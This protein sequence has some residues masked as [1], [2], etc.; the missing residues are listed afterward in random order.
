MILT[1]RETDGITG[2]RLTLGL[3]AIDNGELLIRDGKNIKGIPPISIGGTINHDDLLHLAWSVAGHTIDADIEFPDNI[4]SV[5]GTGG[6]SEIYFDGNDLI[7]DSQVVGAGDFVFQNGSMIIEQNIGIVGDTNLIQLTGANKMLLNGTLEA[8]LIGIGLNTN[9]TAMLWIRD[10]TIDTINYIYGCRIDMTKTAGATNTADTLEGVRVNLIL[11]QVGGTIGKMRGMKQDVTLDEGEI[12]DAG[13]ASSIYVIE[14]YLNLEGG[15]IWGNA[16]GTRI[17]CIQRAVTEV[18][19]DFTVLSLEGEVRDVSD[20]GGTV[21]MLR[22]DDAR[23]L[24]EAFDYNIYQIGTTTNRFGGDLQIASDTNGLVLGSTQQATIKYNGTYNTFDCAGGFNFLNGSV[25]IGYAG[26]PG[27]LLHI[28]EDTFAQ[29]IIERPHNGIYGPGILI[30][31]SRGADTA[32]QDNDLCGGLYFQFLND[33][34]PKTW[35]TAAFIQA[36]VLD[37]SDTT[38]DAQ[39]EFHTMRA[40]TITLGAYLDQNGGFHVDADVGTADDPVALF[41]DYDD[42]KELQRIVQKFDMQR[43]CEIGICEKV[44]G[45][46]YKNQQRFD[47]LLAGGVYQ[48]AERYVKLENRI[49]ELEN[50]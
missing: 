24:S 49:E 47:A 44:D 31:K 11:N 38:E 40:G 42:P 33:G 16:Y 37:A 17:L 1:F 45:R 8:S 2:D 23:V 22:M 18:V 36:K 35:E 13:T 27:A 50:A 30:K 21:S 25:R 19:G 34:T 28:H 4:A 5:Y 7:F 12:G 43:A 3:T 15:K 29:L 26:A 14:S 20:V 41:D 39:L 6:N 9:A 32:A 48:L 10:L 46:Y